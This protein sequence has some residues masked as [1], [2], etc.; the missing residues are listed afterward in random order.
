MHS[1]NFFQ[2]KW[3]VVTARAAQPLLGTALRRSC[4]RFNLLPYGTWS[5]HDLHVI[6]FGISGMFQKEFS[7]L[8]HAAR[9][10]FG[11]AWVFSFFWKLSIFV[12]E[13]RPP[14][15]TDTVGGPCPY[16]QIRIRHVFF[17][18]A[19][20]I[21]VVVDY[22]LSRYSSFSPRGLP[23]LTD[24]SDSHLGN[25]ERLSRVCLDPRG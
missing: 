25:F 13:C 2:C 21:F 19:L 7:W 8:V 20:R 23:T 15:I 11:K 18:W 24:C 3:L 1:E 12:P 6:V 17:F 5:S 14:G 22:W 9:A 10:A 4:C 16:F